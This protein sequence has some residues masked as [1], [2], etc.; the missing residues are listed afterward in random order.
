[1]WWSLRNLMLSNISSHFLPSLDS[2]LMR[3]MSMWLSRQKVKASWRRGLSLFDFP[4]EMCSSKVLMTLIWLA[5]EYALRSSTCLC[6][7]C[8]SWRAPWLLHLVKMIAVFIIDCIEGVTVFNL[9]WKVSWLQG[10]TVPC[11]LFDN[12]WY[13]DVDLWELKGLGEDGLQE[14]L[15]LVPSK[16]M[17][18]GHDGSWLPDLK[19]WGLMP[20]IFSLLCP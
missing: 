18:S 2:S 10:V 7:F 20:R 15:H 4:P 8:L 16:R 12:D 9:I 17:V 6:G 3:M 5:S 11:F 13:N 19:G 1:M 14:I